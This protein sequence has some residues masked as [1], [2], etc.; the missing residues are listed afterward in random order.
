VGL[1]KPDLLESARLPL[2][3]V[4]VGTPTLYDVPSGIVTGADKGYHRGLVDSGRGGVLAEAD[5]ARGAILG[6][7]ADGDEAPG[8]EG[9]VEE[10][11]E[12][13]ESS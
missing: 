8:H 3:D 6:E 10:L 12:H 5:R 4:G 9:D 1:P 11:L 13:E 7:E 2:H